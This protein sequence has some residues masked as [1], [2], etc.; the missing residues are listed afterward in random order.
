MST[1]L[2]KVQMSGIPSKGG[3][4]LLLSSRLILFLV[5]QLIIA[6]VLNS[7]EQSQHFWIL[8]ATVTNVVSILILNQLMK[9]ESER[10]LGL[11]SIKKENIG[12]NLL[13]FGLITLACGPI[14]FLPNQWLSVLFWGNTEIPF[15]MMFQPLSLNLVYILMLFF[16]VTIAL[17]ELATYFAYSL[18]ILLRLF[19]SKFVA[20]ALPVLFLSVQHCTLPFIPDVKFIIYRALVYLPFALLLG[21]TLY[22][23]PQLFP[24]F[25]IMH[26]L[27]DFATV[28]VLYGISK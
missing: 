14:V 26:G 5:F 9:R 11:F 17:A 25:A 22:K 16:P 19:K 7:F 13:F 12:K 24:F 27:L 10:F 6:F 3:I 23:R 28:A 21:F 1:S 20:V 15:K 8:A 4:I 18:P 2:S